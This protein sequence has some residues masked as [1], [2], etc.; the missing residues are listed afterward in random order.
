MSGGFG[1]V[2]DGWAEWDASHPHWLDA[3]LDAV[4][5]CLTLD[6][7]TTMDVW[8]AWRGPRPE[9]PRNVAAVMDEAIRQ[10]LVVRRGVTG[11]HT[12]RGGHAGFGSVYVPVG[13][14]SGGSR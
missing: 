3:G 2:D 7:F 12:R 5:Q 14:V 6:R 10:G 13:A 11:G 8:A 1:D 4:E 9:E